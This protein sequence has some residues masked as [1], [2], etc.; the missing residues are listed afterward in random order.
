MI[1]GILS[2]W[3]MH[4][5]SVGRSHPSIQQHGPAEEGGQ[6]RLQL[7][8]QQGPRRRSWRRGTVGKRLKHRQNVQVDSSG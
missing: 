1:R 2:Q 4:H 6:V 7:L 5:S 3:L 8:P